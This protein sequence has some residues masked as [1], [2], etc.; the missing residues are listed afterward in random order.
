MLLHEG[1][2]HIHSQIKPGLLFGVRFTLKNP[3]EINDSRFP[4]DRDVPQ[5][6]EYVNLLP[7]KQ[8]LT[9]TKLVNIFSPTYGLFL[10][11]GTLAFCLVTTLRLP[12]NQKR[13]HESFH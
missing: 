3:L 5:I 12:G 6:L 11:A 8:Q 10:R 9:L 7:C 2:T 4:S 1:L 13:V